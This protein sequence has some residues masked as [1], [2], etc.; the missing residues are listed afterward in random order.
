MY[1][2]TV[3]FTDSIGQTKSISYTI[4]LGTVDPVTAADATFDLNYGG[5][6][7]V[8]LSTLVTGDV[9]QFDKS[10]IDTSY[11]RGDLNGSV[12]S[13]HSLIDGSNPLERSLYLI[14]SS[15]PMEI[16]PPAQLRLI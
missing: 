13:M 8:D 4:D 10:S 1:P 14:W 7:D 9:A 5:S 12:L 2:L 11:F 6:L 15:A 3:T 16:R